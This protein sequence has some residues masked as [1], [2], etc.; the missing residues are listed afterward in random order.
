MPAQSP[1]IQV[2]VPPSLSSGSA[3]LLTMLTFAVAVTGTSSA[4]IVCS[5]GVTRVIAFTAAGASASAG[6]LPSHI[7]SAVTA[8]TRQAPVTPPTV[9]S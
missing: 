4:T 9:T 6:P 1:P 3:L 7:V 8:M 5:A 2:T